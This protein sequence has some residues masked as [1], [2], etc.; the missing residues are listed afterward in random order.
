MNKKV[1]KLLE[2]LGSAAAKPV[3]TQH[4]AGKSL[5]VSFDNSKVYSPEVHQQA[6]E[7]E[8]VIIEGVKFSIPKRLLKEAP[9]YDLDTKTVHDDR[10]DEDYDKYDVTKRNISKVPTINRPR[11]GNL[12][13]INHDEA[14]KAVMKPGV[15]DKRQL[16]IGSRDNLYVEESYTQEDLL[17][18]FEALE[19]DT[20]KY[21]FE[22]LAEE[23][24]FK[25]EKDLSKLEPTDQEIRNRFKDTEKPYTPAPARPKSELGPKE[26]E[27]KKITNESY[28]REELLELFEAL[29]LDTNKYTFGYLAEEL[30]F[31]AA[32]PVATEHRAG[33]SLKVSF[34]NSKVYSPEVHQEEEEVEAPIIESYTQKDLLELFEALELDTNKYTF[35][36]LAEQLGFQKK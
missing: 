27:P 9:I 6:E 30:G 32:K 15:T 5:K 2:E 21:T 12:V 13:Y 11:V 1:Q 23:L 19:L 18:L 10:H 3:A 28:T 22:F 16:K 24:G 35:E 17:E 31:V 33:K 25:K 34:G 14:S 4:S 7:V 20:D 29:N 8:A 36:Y 26:L